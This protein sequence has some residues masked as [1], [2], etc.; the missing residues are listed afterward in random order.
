M[1]LL[2]CNFYSYRQ[3]KRI[4]CSDISADILY[5]HCHGRS[6][7]DLREFPAGE[8]GGEYEFHASPTGKQEEARKI[9][10]EYYS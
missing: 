5:K 8:Y 10:D 7:T 1:G 9:Y 6:D 2:E 3:Q 4:P